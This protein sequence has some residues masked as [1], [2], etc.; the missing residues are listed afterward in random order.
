MPGW[1][2]RIPE[3]VARC[4]C[5]ER[6]RLWAMLS[7]QAS[8]GCCTRSCCQARVSAVMCTRD[9]VLALRAQAMHQRWMC[10]RC[11]EPVTKHARNFEC[12]DRS[13]MNVRAKKQARYHPAP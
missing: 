10:P 9:E 12:L 5:T 11:G 2:A 1:N 8:A 6:R 3:G 4:T 13:V 7:P